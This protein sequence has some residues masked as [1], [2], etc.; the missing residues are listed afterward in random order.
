MN[1]CFEIA[2]T[3]PFSCHFQKLYRLAP[4]LHDDE[5]Q[6]RPYF[7][8]SLHCDFREADWRYRMYTLRT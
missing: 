5:T 1:G 2:S 7:W 6:A 3:S 8:P 4:M